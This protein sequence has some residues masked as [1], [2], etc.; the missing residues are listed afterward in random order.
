MEGRTGDK[1]RRKEG[2]GNGGS[3]EERKKGKSLSKEEKLKVSKNENS[4]VWPPVTQNCTEH[5]TWLLSSFNKKYV[6][7]RF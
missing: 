3:T 4:E 2:K 5:K 1:V 6:K 7:E